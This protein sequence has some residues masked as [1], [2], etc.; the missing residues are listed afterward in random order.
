MFTDQDATEAMIRVKQAADG[1]DVLV[2][3]QGQGMDGYSELA[4]YRA[5]LDKLIKERE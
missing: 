3:N 2:S 4:N 1:G 5:V